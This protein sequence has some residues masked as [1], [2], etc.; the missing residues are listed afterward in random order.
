MLFFKLRRHC[1][2]TPDRTLD[3]LRKPGYIEKI[4]CKVLFCGVFSAVDVCQIAD[5][6]EC[7]KGDAERQQE[8][9][10]G[11]KNFIPVFEAG[12]NKKMKEQNDDENDPFFLLNGS[13]QRF[14]RAA[15]KGGIL[16]LCGKGSLKGKE[17]LCSEVGGDG[18]HEQ[19]KNPAQAQNRII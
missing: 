16:L 1:V 9:F 18:I 4:L 12:E 5:R 15:V 17:E 11:G 8:S 2:K 7:I 10:G 3:Y 14:P 13:F 6:H 19:E